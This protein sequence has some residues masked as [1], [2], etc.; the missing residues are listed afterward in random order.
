MTALIRDSQ[1]NLKVDKKALQRI[2]ESLLTCSGLQDRDLSLLLVDNKEI[3]ALNQ[4]FFGR[5]KPTNVISFSYIDGPPHEI[6]GDIIIS[7]ERAKTEAEEAGLPFYERLS[8]LIVHGFVHILGFDHEAGE[9]ERRRMRY[10]EKKFLRLLAANVQCSEI[11]A[12]DLS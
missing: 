8:A 12:R 10:R 3:Q 9:R 1:K 5:D 11:L 6:L 7:V 2:T 4:K